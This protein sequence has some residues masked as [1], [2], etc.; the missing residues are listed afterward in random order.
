AVAEAVG[1]PVIASGGAGTLDHL[2]GAL[3]EGGAYAA[4]AAASF[5][6]GEWSVQ[7]AK[8]YLRRKGVPVRD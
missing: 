2:Y 3:T 8:A 1:V 6:F 5:H 7:D 4:R